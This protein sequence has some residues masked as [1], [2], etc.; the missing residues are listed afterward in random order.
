MITSI[1]GSSFQGYTSEVQDRL[2]KRAVELLLN[3][4]KI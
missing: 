4:I 2:A 3:G 1:L